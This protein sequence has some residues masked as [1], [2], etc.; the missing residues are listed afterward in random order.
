MAC[1]IALSIPHDL[2]MGPDGIARGTTKYSVAGYL[3]GRR[4]GSRNGHS[5]L[6]KDGTLHSFGWLS[7]FPFLFF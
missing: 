6:Q 1:I 3:R 7:F 4:Q 5:L 2:V